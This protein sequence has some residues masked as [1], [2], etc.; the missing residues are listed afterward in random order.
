MSLLYLHIPYCKRICAYC[1]FYRTASLR[2]LP[3]AVEAMH[4][5][6][7]QRS[8]YLPDPNIRTIYF[9]GGTPSLLPPGQLQRLIDTAASLWDCLHT[10]EITV[11]VNPDDV[12][13]E[14]V[15]E[16]RRTRIDRISLGIQSFDDRVLAM[17][18]RRHTASE[19]VEAVRRLQE[20]GYDNISADLI[21]GVDGS[22]EESLDRSIDRLLDLNVAHVSAYHLTIEPGTVF[23]R[24]L[25][26]GKMRE[27]GEERYEREFMKIHRALTQAG[28]EH[29]EVSNYAL[30][31]RRARHN[32]AYW[33]GEAYLGIGAGAHSFDGRERRWC[34]STAEEYAHGQM[35]YESETLGP[36]ESFD[37]YV[38][39]SLRRCEGIDLE[40]IGRR[41]GAE[42]AA[43]TLE[44]AQRWQDSGDVVVEHGRIRIPPERFMISDAVIESLF[45]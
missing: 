31:G 38:M 13:P 44:A 40:T 7:R 19:A 21:F 4:D 26:A 2:T 3:S 20:A 24:R 32:S 18:N 5:E 28:Y 41:F 43:K 17:M 25:A 35:R 8:G 30:V 39:V 9:G 10:E 29:Y 1:D 14:Y 12:T 22:G 36:T 37:E 45:A 34:I 23:G 33:T 42:R 15:A 27:V 6:M 11:E 16:L